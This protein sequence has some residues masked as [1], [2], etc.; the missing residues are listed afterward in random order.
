MPIYEYSC[1]KCG[2]EF[3]ELVWSDDDEVKCPNC[4]SDK[5]AKLM[6]CCRHKHGGPS[7]PG[8]A[9]AAPASGGG[10]GGCTGGNCS[11]C[12]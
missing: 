2:S 11:S 1:G 3:E 10:C 9:P 7:V 4:G 5:T 12:G 6:S 8:A